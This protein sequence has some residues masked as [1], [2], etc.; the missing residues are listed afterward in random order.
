MNNLDLVDNTGVTDFLIDGLTYDEAVRHGAVL[1]KSS[2]TPVLDARI[3]LMEAAKVDAADLISRAATK[4]EPII[5][6]KYKT[7]LLRR[8]K[9]EP[10][11]YIVGYKGFW[12]EH[13]L[14]TPDVLI[15]RA[16]SE[17]IIETVLAL[18]S[19]EECHNFSIVDAGT[20]S[21]CLLGSL[22]G[23]YPDARGVGIDRSPKA[24][25]VAKRNMAALNLTNRTQIVE[26]N[27]FDSVCGPIDIIVSNPPYI[28][29]ADYRKLCADIRD[30]EPESALVSKRR[31]QA[32]YT[33]IFQQASSIIASRGLIVVEIGDGHEEFLWLL[34]QEQFPNGKVCVHKD[35]NNRPRAISVDLQS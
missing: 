29:E 14:V 7:M 15:P 31:G 35:L 8:L 30:Y 24:I 16:D 22:L 10:V 9:A 3:L 19:P 13:Y 6:A 12:R 34:A 2:E 5:A 25:L 4:I 26:G 11:A 18:R 1:L 33:V 20:G 21:G 27:W 23:M 32:D 17:C 28:P